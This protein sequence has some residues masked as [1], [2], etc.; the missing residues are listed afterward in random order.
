MMSQDERDRLVLLRQWQEGLVTAV[1]AA[2]RLRLTVRHFRRLCRRFEAEG[3]RA[4]LP[5][6]RS[7]RGNPRYAT[8]VRQ[9][10]V[11]QAQTPLYADFGP[12]LLSEHLPVP[13]PAWTVRRWLIE[14]DHW[15][16]RQR[17]CKH[18]RRRPRRPRYGE[19]VLM[20]TSQH[21][22]LEGR[23]PETLVL[24]AM[25]DDATNDLH[26]RF[27]ARDTGVANQLVLMEWLRSRGRMQAL[28]TDQA[29]HFSQSADGRR[30]Q[31]AIRKGLQSMGS[32]LILALSPQAKGR[33]E[34]LFGTLQDRLVKEMRV[35]GVSCMAEA[36]AFLD[37]VF[38][39]FWK[40][41]FKIAPVDFA[42]AHL[43][44]EPALNLLRAFA[45]TQSRVIAKDYTI[46]Y[47]NTFWQIEAAQADPNMPLQRVQVEQW[48]DGSLHFYWRERE[49]APTRTHGDPAS[50]PARWR[51]PPD[52][53]LRGQRFGTFEDGRSTTSRS[54]N[55][56]PG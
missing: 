8:D 49:I 34:R 23:S 47:R 46:R 4:V 45:E 40:R 28:Y 6:P 14:A 20:D 41:R 39:P 11:R 25:I 44:L 38:I 31:S 30:T 15:K 17:R 10:V 19:L 35:A 2:Q 16:V 51:P 1:E 27:V 22:W 36:N 12:T 29:S 42:D 18:R 56:Q 26:A 48:P 13:V 3:D 24:I 52:H 5:L 43:P 33:V 9:A 53:R 7:R 37:H 54:S 21:D 32:E 50:R 55:L